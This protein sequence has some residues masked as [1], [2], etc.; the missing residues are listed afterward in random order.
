MIWRILKRP[1]NGQSIE[2]SLRSTIRAGYAYM[3]QSYGRKK[4][5]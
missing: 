1:G 4:S 2:S 5:T 3:K